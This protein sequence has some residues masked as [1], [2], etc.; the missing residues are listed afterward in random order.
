LPRCGMAPHIPTGYVYMCVCT[1]GLILVFRLYRP[2]REGNSPLLLVTSRILVYRLLLVFLLSFCLE[3]FR[4]N[5]IFVHIPYI[6]GSRGSA[7]GIATGYGLDDR[8]VGVRVPVGS[9]IFSSTRRPDWLWGPTSLLSN[10]YRG[11]FPRG[12]ASG[13]GHGSRAG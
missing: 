4:E 13:A 9:R 3:S 1:L 10:G 7:V 12:K 2:T 8:G 11:S 5:L 6:F